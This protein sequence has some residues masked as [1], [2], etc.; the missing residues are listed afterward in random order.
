MKP[1]VIRTN[2]LKL[3]IQIKEKLIMKFNQHSQLIHKTV[4]ISSPC[5]N[6]FSDV[7]NYKQNYFMRKRRVETN[8]THGD[9]SRSPKNVSR[10]F[11]DSFQ[12]ML[13]I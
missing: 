8:D 11:P 2:V 6:N 10:K 13:I 3:E 9:A 4:L 12:M 5:V 7:E 1:S